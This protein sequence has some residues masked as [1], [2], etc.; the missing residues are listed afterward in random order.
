VND[1]LIWS[2]DPMVVT[3]VL[4]KIYMLKCAFI[5]GNY[6]VGNSEFHGESWKNHRLESTFSEKFS[7]TFSM[8]MFLML[9]RE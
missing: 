7:D 1:T 9:F 4:E 6:L 3:K 8:S 5:P 2:K